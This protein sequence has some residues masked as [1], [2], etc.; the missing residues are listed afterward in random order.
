MSLLTLPADMVL[1]TV[2]TPSPSIHF[3]R[4]ADG[5]IVGVRQ[6]REGDDMPAAGETDIG[7]YSLSKRAYLRDLKSYADAP[8][9]EASTRERNFLPFI[10]WLAA[11]RPV[12]TI[13]CVD[14][15]EAAGISTEEDLRRL[16][17]HLRDADREN[18]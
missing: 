9:H 18:D 1:P 6:L 8:G 4:S 10:P 16:E 11:S 7:L 3:E 13:P 14:T 12:V 2:V 15:D 5:R 17:A